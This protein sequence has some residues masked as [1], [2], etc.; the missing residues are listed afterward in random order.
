MGIQISSA[1]FAQSNVR[2]VSSHVINGNN[3]SAIKLP[4]FQFTGN[5]RI[6]ELYGA[7]TTQLGA[8]HTAPYFDQYDGNT[9]IEL[10]S[11][12][13]PPDA[14]NYPVGSLLLAYGKAATAM[15]GKSATGAN[16]SQAS[17]ANL[18]TFQ[19]TVLTSI[20]GGTTQI[21]YVYSTSDAPTVG[22]IDFYAVVELLDASSSF[23]A[24]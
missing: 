2:V 24:I 22:A 12:T 23:S 16:I 17:A 4:V 3:A 19:E 14:S 8:H 9:R 13:L 15:L 1:P 6:R 5:I 10:T 11:S 21:E 7:V 20:S 18:D